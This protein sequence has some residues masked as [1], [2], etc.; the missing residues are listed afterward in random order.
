M[1]FSP[2]YISVGTVPHMIHPETRPPMSNR[3]SMGDIMAVMESITVFCM[4]S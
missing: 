1:A 2:A 4:V 3:I